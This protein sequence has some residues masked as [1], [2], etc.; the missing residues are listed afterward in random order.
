ML[1]STDIRCHYV[2]IAAGKQ[3]HYRQCG[4]GPVLFLLHP[5][6]QSSDAMLPAME[7]FSRVC[8]CIALDTAGYGLSDPIKDSDAAIED[9]GDVVADVASALGYEQFYLYGAATGAQIGIAIGKRYPT[10]VRQLLLDV[11]GHFSD[12]ERER[13]LTDYFPSVAPQRDGAHLT[14]YW[15][16][17]RHLFLAFP[18]NSQRAV[19]QLTYDEPPAFVLQQILLRYLRAGE[20]YHG[21]Y[22]TAFYS[23]QHRFM[24]GLEVPTT[25]TRTPSSMVVAYTDELIRRGLTN[26]IQ[27]L[28]AGSGPSDRYDIQREHLTAVIGKQADLTRSASAVHAPAASLQRAYWRLG[29]SQMHIL[30]NGVTVGTPIVIV[31]DGGESSV[32]VQAFAAS[33][34]LDRPVIA[35]D[36]PGHGATPAPEGFVG[37]SATDF[38]RVLAQAINENIGSGAA[39][40][41]FGFGGAAVLAGA[42]DCEL[43]AVTVIDPIP[44]SQDELEQHQQNGVPDLA[45]RMDGSHLLTTWSYASDRQRYWPWFVRRGA[46][47]LAHQAVPLDELHQKCLDLIYSAPILPNTLQAGFGADWASLIAAAKIDV[48]LAVSNRHPNPERVAALCANE[49]ELVNLDDDQ[50]K[51]WSQLNC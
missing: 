6:P 49:S 17:V 12:A 29:K 45:P 27:V 11:V 24:D 9:Y 21:A 50:S 51:Y 37:S 39:S 44:L 46:A 10:R 25:I 19:D 7:A 26:N 1:D 16:M 18:W 32:Q 48:R 40:I 30:T 47:R 36:L 5:S 35:V 43:S 20:N 23:E 28:N 3:V 22:R 33:L 4:E 41:G 13:I 34:G 38:G 2:T 31:H 8:T 42:A 14:T 15:D